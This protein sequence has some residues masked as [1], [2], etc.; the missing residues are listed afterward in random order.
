MPEPTPEPTEERT[1]E[2]LPEPTLELMPGLTP[3]L[4]PEPT[5]GPTPEPMPEPMPGISCG[6]NVEKKCYVMFPPVTGNNCSDSKLINE[7]TMIWKSFSI[8]DVEAFKG[9]MKSHFLDLELTQKL[10]IM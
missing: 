9:V 4:T 10:L 5:P 6:L 3:E 1:P 2:P 8:I 7:L